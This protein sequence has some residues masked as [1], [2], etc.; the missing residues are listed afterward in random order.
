LSEVLTPTLPRRLDSDQAN[1]VPSRS[2][3]AR[4]RRTREMDV[5]SLVAAGLTNGAI[6]ARLVLSSKTVEKH[7]GSL[8]GKMRAR[9][10]KALAR[11]LESAGARDQNA[12]E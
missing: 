12:S 9:D 11:I 8:L 7:P 4:G 10:R 1:A 5:L 3:S 2:C 6:A